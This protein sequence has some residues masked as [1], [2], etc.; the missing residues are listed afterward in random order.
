MNKELLNER[1][2][3]AFG[4]TITI[5][6]VTIG[7]SFSLQSLPEEEQ[8]FGLLSMMIVKPKMSVKAIKDLPAKYMSDIT[9]LINESQGKH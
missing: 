7:E 5:R 6:D 2:I 1:E 9:K 8:A 4:K 3:E